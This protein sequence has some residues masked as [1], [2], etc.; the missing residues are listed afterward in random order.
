[1]NGHQNGAFSC[2][3]GALK[4]PRKVN[5]HGADYALMEYGNYLLIVNSDNEIYVIE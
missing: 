3:I 1:M 5:G 2:L 4:N